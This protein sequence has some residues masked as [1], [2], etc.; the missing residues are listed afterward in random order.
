MNEENRKLDVPDSRKNQMPES[1]S[2]DAQLQLLAAELGR[3]VGAT[4][5]KIRVSPSVIVNCRKNQL[6][7]W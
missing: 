3:I 4:W 6:A 5:L 1:S 7:T 2:E